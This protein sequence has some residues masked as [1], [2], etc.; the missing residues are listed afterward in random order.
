MDTLQRLLHFFLPA[1][2][3]NF[4]LHHVLQIVLDLIRTLAAAPFERFERLPRHFVYLVRVDVRRAVFLGE[5]GCEF[6]R[7]LAEDQKIGK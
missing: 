5:L 6:S 3:A 2:D 1:D 4:V 7:A